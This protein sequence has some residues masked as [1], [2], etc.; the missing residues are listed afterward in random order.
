L[1]DVAAVRTAV[2]AAGT[3]PI[4]VDPDLGALEAAL[5]ERE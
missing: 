4:V 5:E 2:A 3:E 1:K